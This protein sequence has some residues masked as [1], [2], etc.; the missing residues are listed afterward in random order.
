MLGPS[1]LSFTAPR[2]MTAAAP[3]LFD[4]SRGPDGGLRGDDALPK[5]DPPG[6]R[7]TG[8]RGVAPESAYTLTPCPT[9]RATARVS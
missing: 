5:S 2:S 3:R 1:L 4:G 9:A 7:D 8:R 6:R